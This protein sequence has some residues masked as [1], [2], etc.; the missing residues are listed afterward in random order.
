MSL[1]T[2]IFSLALFE[3]SLGASV[4]VTIPGVPVALPITVNGPDDKPSSGVC[5]REVGLACE[6]PGSIM[7]YDGPECCYECV[8]EKDHTTT[9][10]RTT[11]LP[12]V[13]N[14]PH[15]TMYLNP[16]TCI[17]ELYPKCKGDCHILGWYYTAPEDG[18]INNVADNDGLVF[19]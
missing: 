19:V 8:C 3:L 4:P 13:K 2:I 11:A 10:C 18:G 6:V 12:H 17:N 14:A 1:L 7:A 5:V 16:D 15:C 9:C